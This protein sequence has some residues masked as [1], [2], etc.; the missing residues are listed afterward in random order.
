MAADAGEQCTTP[1]ETRRH[2]LLSEALTGFVS[3]VDSYDEALIF[4]KLAA[5]FHLVSSRLAEITLS[6]ICM[7]KTI[8][9]LACKEHLRLRPGN[10][11][12]RQ[13]PSDQE[14]VAREV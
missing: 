8:S 11:C 3:A 12:V 9:G 5:L 7:P 14:F 13:P 1:A 10:L 6:P 2:N 4:S